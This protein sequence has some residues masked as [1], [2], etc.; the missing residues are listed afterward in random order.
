MN[1]VPRV[2]EPRLEAL[3]NERDHLRV[4]I[5][6]AE[7]GG[8]VEAA[9]LEEAKRRLAAVDAQIAEMPSR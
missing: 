3:L 7:N 9:L 6:L 4:Q 2:P 8:P 1:R 5:N